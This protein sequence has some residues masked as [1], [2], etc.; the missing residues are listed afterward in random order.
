MSTTLTAVRGE[1]KMQ[2][3]LYTRAVRQA[4]KDLHQAYSDSPLLHNI[5]AEHEWERDY[6]YAD[7]RSFIVVSYRLH[8]LFIDIAEWNKQPAESNPRYSNDEDG[9]FAW[10]AMNAD[11]LYQKYPDRWILVEK[12]RVAGSAS[13]PQELME[14]ART[15]GIQEPFIT[16]TTPPELPGKAV[17]GGKVV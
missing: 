13:E 15:L 5:P 8:D 4:R 12:A 1:R 7:A 3:Q 10:V 2:D 16:I 9:S 6:G 14:L 11:A 17:Y